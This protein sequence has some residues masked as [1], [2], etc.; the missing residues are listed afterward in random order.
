MDGGVIDYGLAEIV[1]F[2]DTLEEAEREAIALNEEVSKRDYPSYNIW[3]VECIKTF[4]KNGVV[5][6]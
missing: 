4:K 2:Y 3:I 5:L 1:G 6:K